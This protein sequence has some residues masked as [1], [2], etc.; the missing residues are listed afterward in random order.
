MSESLDPSYE[1]KLSDQE[2]KDKL[3][4][5]YNQSSNKEVVKESKFPTE[6]VDL[7]S[8]G[9][10]YPKDNPLSSGKIELKYMTA[11]EEDILTTQS[12]IKQGVVIDKLL[13]S[14]IVSNGEGK[15]IKWNLG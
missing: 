11:K 13:Q 3:T 10:L 15:G 8:Q 9:L 7:P 14:M 4:E 2:L 1:N 5:E 12:Y 6:I